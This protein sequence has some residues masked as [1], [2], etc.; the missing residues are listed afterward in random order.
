[1]PK[2]IVEDQDISFRVN[3]GANLREALLKHK[4]RLYHGLFNRL[5]NCHGHGMCG[6]CLVRVT[7]NPAGLTDRTE[8]EK[9]KLFESNPNTRLACQAEVC[10]DVIVNCEPEYLGGE[11][12]VKNTT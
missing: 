3:A 2:V 1:M 12:P 10:G 4:A 7:S 6:T 9:R 11:D 8:V 5:F